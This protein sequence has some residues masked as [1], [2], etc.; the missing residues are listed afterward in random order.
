MKSSTMLCKAQQRIKSKQDDYICVA[1]SESFGAKATT[2]L[3]EEILRRIYPH[4]SAASW[5][6]AQIGVEP[7][8]YTWTEVH[9]DEL[10][11]WRIRWL[12]QMI[13]EYESKGD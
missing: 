11:K 3:R 13:G 4:C 6:I 7:E 1:L 2:E 8:N 5:L 12:D 9:K 10:R